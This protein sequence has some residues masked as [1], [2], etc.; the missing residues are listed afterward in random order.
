MAALL[1]IFAGALGCALSAYG[2]SGPNE[3]WSLFGCFTFAIS[4]TLLAIGW[5]EHRR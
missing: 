1:L 5:R 4:F 2:I 3:G